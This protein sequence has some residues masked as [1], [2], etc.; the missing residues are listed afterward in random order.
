MLKRNYNRGALHLMNINK[1]VTRHVRFNTVL[2]RIKFTRNYLTGWIYQAY[3]SA[4]PHSTRSIYG[5][6]PKVKRSRDNTH[7]LLSASVQDSHRERE[8]E[9]PKNKILNNSKRRR[10][11]PPGADIYG[12]GTTRGS[13][14]SPIIRKSKKM[15]RV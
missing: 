1:M 10:N 15:S 8:R 4:G 14:P 2:C 7:V 11:H 13:P 6:K 9:R 5:R 3:V 12:H